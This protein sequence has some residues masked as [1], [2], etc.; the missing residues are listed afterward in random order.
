MMILELANIE[1]L[2][3]QNSAFEAALEQAKKVISQSKG[4]VRI[5]VNK[6][7]EESNRY[8]FFIYWETLEDHTIGF[9]GSDLFTQWRALIGP[10]FANPPQ[11]LHYE[12]QI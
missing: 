9:R 5:E 12:K 10:F 4:F 11:V 1:I 2:A 6:C 3:G 8:T 7:I